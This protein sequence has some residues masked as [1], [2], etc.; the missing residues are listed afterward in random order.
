MAWAAM[1]AGGFMAAL[2]MGHV[3]CEGRFSGAISSSLAG[4]A[5]IRLGLVATG[6]AALLRGRDVTLADALP[7]LLWAAAAALLAWARGTGA[8]GTSETR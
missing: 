4:A 7:A 3:G 6:G 5:L 2:A 8:A 1:L